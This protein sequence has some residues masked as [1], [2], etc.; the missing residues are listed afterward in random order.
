[1]LPSGKA[2]ISVQV[3]VNPRNL[4]PTPR[5]PLIK[6]INPPKLKAFGLIKSAKSI[7]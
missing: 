3:W 1:M 5:P 7:K 4:L 6:M 2:M